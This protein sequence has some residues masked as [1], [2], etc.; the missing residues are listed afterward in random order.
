MLLEPVK[1]GVVNK[2]RFMEFFVTPGST[3]KRFGLGN[4]PL[5]Q[6]RQIPVGKFTG[7]EG[8]FPV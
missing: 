1:A 3:G 5:F 7:R 8:A 4:K 2:T 6:K